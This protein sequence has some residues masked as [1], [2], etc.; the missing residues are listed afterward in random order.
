MVFQPLHQVRCTI[1]MV[2]WNN[3]L[4]QFTDLIDSLH[5]D[6]T[7]CSGDGRVMLVHLEMH[8]IVWYTYFIVNST[9]INQNIYCGYSHCRR[10]HRHHH[11]NHHHQHHHHL[12][13]LGS[14]AH[15]NYVHSKYQSLVTRYAISHFH[16]WKHYDVTNSIQIV[17]W[18]QQKTI[19]Q[20]F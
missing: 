14:R 6:Y 7:M 11:R 4:S 8:V 16:M 20:I 18:L 12:Y 15:W 1:Y 9:V 17:V 3:L 19:T 13:M 2:T 10:H 5:A